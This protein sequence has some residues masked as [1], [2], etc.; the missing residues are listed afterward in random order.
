[1]HGTMAEMTSEFTQ[2]VQA[3]NKFGLTNFNYIFYSVDT[4]TRRLFLLRTNGAWQGHERVVTFMSQYA[5]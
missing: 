3:H 5:G 2:A 1:M 4:T